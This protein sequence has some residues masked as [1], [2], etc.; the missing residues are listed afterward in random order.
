METKKQSTNWKIATIYYLV[1]GL[2]VPTIIAAAIVTFTTSIPI[3]LG[4]KYSFISSLFNVG[5]APVTVIINIFAI[6]LGVKYAVGFLKKR[7][8]IEDV[9][10]IIKLAIIYM[11]IVNGTWA[12]IDFGLQISKGIQLVDIIALFNTVI[13]IIFFYIFSKKYLLALKSPDRDA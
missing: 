7:Y 12:L 11:V 5:V 9:K 3:I 10:D 4:H 1:G 6:W 2:V 13:S 8:I